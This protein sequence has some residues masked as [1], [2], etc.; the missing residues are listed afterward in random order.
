MKGGYVYILA[1]KSGVL[2]TGVTSRLTRRMVEHRQKLLQGFT[3]RYNV[4]RLVYREQFG[5]IRTAIAR[6]K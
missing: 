4:T 5:D 6:D 2:Y 1:S 3:K